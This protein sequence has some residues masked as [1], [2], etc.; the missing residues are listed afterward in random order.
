MAHSD[1]N[2]RRQ[3]LDE[4]RVAV[5]AADWDRCEQLTFQALVGLPQDLQLTLP[6]LLLERYLGDFARRW[7]NADWARA[8]LAN[9]AL[10]EGD[11]NEARSAC[12]AVF[13][14]ADG[15]FLDGILYL[16]IAAAAPQHPTWFGLS[17]VRAATRAHGAR[18]FSDADPEA[19]RRYEEDLAAAERDVAPPAACS[20]ARPSPD[21]HPAFVAAVAREWTAALDHLTALQIWTY[22]DRDPA[23]VEQEFA[24]WLPTRY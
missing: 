5:A 24:E 21:V 22:P 3:L 1:P 4:L 14:R 2:R 8:Q 9:P 16:T 7:P 20:P 10:P 17:A 23:L 18:A 15:R 11:F 6:Q 12:P 13:D 19:A